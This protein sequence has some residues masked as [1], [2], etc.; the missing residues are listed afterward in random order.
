MNILFNR[1]N[2]NGKVFHSISNY[3]CY[4]CDGFDRNVGLITRKEGIL[5][6]I[7]NNNIIDE[8]LD[9][10]VV[11]GSCCQILGIDS[12]KISKK[13]YTHLYKDASEYGKYHM[14][15][16]DKNVVPDKLCKMFW[17]YF[18]INDLLFILNEI[19]SQTPDKVTDIV[20]N[21][22]KLCET[23]Y[24]NCNLPKE[25]SKLILE[26]S[27]EYYVLNCYLKMSDNAGKKND[28]N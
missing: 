24:Q 7:T 27:N 3:I 15:F 10:F 23:F 26:K 11:C 9:L 13:K 21:Y 19:F 20:T 16:Y 4:F 5:Y 2:I 6:D 22:E 12:N 25:I 1:Q 18:G 8:S 28:L 14:V 17:S